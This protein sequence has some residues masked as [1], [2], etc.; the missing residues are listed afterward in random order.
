MDLELVIQEMSELDAVKILFWQYSPPYDWYNLEGCKE[1]ADEMLDEKYYV[2]KDENGKLIGFYC[3]RASAQVSKGKELGFYEDDSY[4]DIG[5]GMNPLYC[6]KRLGGEFLRAGML[7]AKEQ[8]QA[9]KF[10]LTVAEFN[11]LAIRTYEKVGFSIVGSFVR[12]N[13]I[14]RTTFYVMIYELNENNSMG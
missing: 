8:F 4:L 2:G 7:F 11:V 10:R 13:A 9:V 14:D 12:E 6:G 5:L 1:C 3:Y